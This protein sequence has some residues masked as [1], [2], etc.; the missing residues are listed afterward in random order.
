MN[1]TQTLVLIKPDGIQRGMLGQI[2]KAFED[3][4]LAIIGVRSFIF[5]DELLREHYAHLADKPFF[6]GIA[7]FMKSDICVALCIAGVDAVE[8]VR[9][10]VGVTNGREA[11]AG[12]IRGDY[13]MSIQK[14]L[15]H[16]SDSLEAAEAEIARFFPEGVP[17]ERFISR[18]SDFYSDDELAG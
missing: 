13:S 17:G 18:A 7:D 16:A 4:G 6:K 8:V 2:I 12:T 1:V 5:T 3:K 9:K 10:M 14:N 15:V 11:S